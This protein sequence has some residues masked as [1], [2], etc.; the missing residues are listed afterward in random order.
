VRS[1]GV[2]TLNINARATR[3]CVLAA[4]GVAGQ[5]VMTIKGVNGAL[6]MAVPHVAA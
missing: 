1:F 3:S 5:R 2:I 6:V 4:R